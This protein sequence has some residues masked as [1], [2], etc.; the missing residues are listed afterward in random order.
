MLFLEMYQNKKH[1]SNLHVLQG[2]FLSYYGIN[3]ISH[4]GEY[5]KLR[6]CHLKTV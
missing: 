1:V 3:A 6:T 5:V 4:Y 2:L